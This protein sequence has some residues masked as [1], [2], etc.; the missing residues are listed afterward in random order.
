MSACPAYRKG[1]KGTSTFDF[2]CDLGILLR[3]S[4]EEMLPRRRCL[5]S[6]PMPY[7]IGP[8]LRVFLAEFNLDAPEGR[9][10][11]LSAGIERNQV[12]RPQLIADLAESLVQLLLAFCVIIL[13]AGII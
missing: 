2:L 5:I 3:F 6:R 12:L 9:I 4:I 13:A 8:A 10:R 7:L 1:R 11:N